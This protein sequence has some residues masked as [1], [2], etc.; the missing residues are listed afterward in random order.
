MYCAIV[1]RICRRGVVH[2]DPM[3]G[4]LTGTISPAATPQTYQVTVMV[5]DSVNP[6]VSLSFDWCV[7]APDVQPNIPPMILEPQLSC[8]STGDSVN[9]TVL[10]TDPDDSVLRYSFQNLPPG[11]VHN[12]P[13]SGQLTGNISP[14]ATPQTYHVTV[15]VID[16]VNPAVSLSFDWC[17]E[18]SDNPVPDPLPDECKFILT[19]IAGV[20]Y[21]VIK[22]TNKADILHGTEGNDLIFGYG[23]KDTIYGKGGNDCIFGGEGQDEISGGDWR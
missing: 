4:Q 5:I 11:V 8:F 13:M 21:K 16:S 7:E 1:S 17:V 10:A 20:D 12:D 6:A 3:S 19:G 22:G 18:A 9:I 14:A 23:G 2:N 15:M